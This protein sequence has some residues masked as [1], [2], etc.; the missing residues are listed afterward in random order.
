M[1]PNHKLL[2]DTNESNCSIQPALQPALPGN[3]LL[4]KDIPCPQLIAIFNQQ[5]KE[6]TKRVWVTR[7][8][9]H[10]LNSMLPCGTEIIW[11]STAT[12]M[13]FRKADTI[14]QLQSIL[15]EYIDCENSTIIIERFDYLVNRY[16]K[17]EVMNLLYRIK[18]RVL[19]SKS[20]I[21]LSVES[22]SVPAEFL[23]SVKQEFE[24][25]LPAVTPDY[26]GIRYD[27]LKMIEYI[28]SKPNSD[29][30]MMSTSLGITRT[31]CRRRMYALR[32]L[33]LISI[34]INGR[35]KAVAMTE[36][37]EGYKPC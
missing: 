32:E 27:L 37:G 18:D 7:S 8:D 14:K 30:G 25:I 2:K 24:Q 36:K 5:I 11:M 19:A 6:G 4:A 20:T 16:G 17:E 13:A 26:I 9:P 31:T 28:R 34:K 3:C 29:V 21:I 33:G 23:A 12:D 1:C 10:K 22:S 35:K 15:Q